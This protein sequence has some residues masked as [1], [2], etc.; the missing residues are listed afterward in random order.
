VDLHLNKINIGAVADRAVRGVGL[1]GLLALTLGPIPLQQANPAT[2]GSLSWGGNSSPAAGGGT[3]SAIAAAD[4]SN[5]D[6]FAAAGSKV[7]RSTNGGLEWSSGTTISKVV[8]A[9]V[10]AVPDTS[11]A[12]MDSNAVAAIPGVDAD[13]MVMDLRISPNY[14]QDGSI[15]ALCNT[16]YTRTGEDD[17]NTNSYV[18]VSTNNGNSWTTSTYLND[19]ATMDAI[20]ASA[21]DIAPNFD[22]NDGGDIA[23]GLASGAT[24]TMFAR[25]TGRGFADATPDDAEMGSNFGP[26]TGGTM[27]SVLA[28]SFSPR[29]TSLSIVVRVVRGATAVMEDRATIN[30]GNAGNVPNGAF[31]AGAMVVPAAGDADDGD[32]ASIVWPSDIESTANNYWVGV[33]VADGGG[34]YRSS[35]TFQNLNAPSDTITGLVATGTFD[36]ANMYA[37]DT[38][39]RTYRSTNGGDRW[40]DAEDIDGDQDLG[41]LTGA[42]LLAMDGGGTLYA[43]SADA[44]SGV[45]RSTNGGSSWS[46][47]GLTNTAY[48]QVMDLHAVNGATLFGVFSDGSASSVFRTDNEGSSGDWL[49]VNRSEGVSA[50]ECSPN[51]SADGGCYLLRGGQSEQQVLRS[52]NGGNNFALT[53]SDPSDDGY[54]HTMKVVSSS[55]VFVG[56]SE[57]HVIRTSDGGFTWDM[58]STDMG[59]NVMDIAISPEFATDNTLLVSVRST[60]D[61]YEVWMSSDGGATF[62]QVGSSS[63]PWDSGSTNGRD[64]WGDVEFSPL[65]PTD[66]TVYF[67]PDK[68]AS[69]D[70]I[71]RKDLSSTSNWGEVGGSL[72][73]SPGE[74][75]SQLFLFEAAGSPDGYAI[76]GSRSGAAEF[77]RHYSPLSGRNS[78]D[79][80]ASDNDGAG[81]FDSNGGNAYYNGQ[82]WMINGNKIRSWS[83]SNPFNSGVTLTSPLPG[84]SVPTNTGDNGQPVAFNWQ[85][86][87]DD[88]QRY[89]IQVALDPKFVSLI[90]NTIVSV[91][92]LSLGTNQLGDGATYYWR[93]RV[94]GTDQTAGDGDA[95]TTTGTGLPSSKVA[96]PGPWS[97]SQNFSV[98]STG[99]PTAPTASL[100][101]NNAQLP[102]L[103]TNLS[104]NNPSGT[105]QVQ[106]Q[107]TPLNGD[108]PGIDLIYGSSISNYS[109][110]APSFGVGPYVMLPGATYTWRVR[111]TRAT[112]SIGS[113]DSS[114][115][116]FSDPRTF[117]TAAPNAGTIQGLA[118]INGEAT[119]DTTP[120]LQWKDANAAMFY[121]EVQLSSDPNFG[122]AGAVAPVYWNLI[123]A[124]VSTPPSSWT[125]PDSAALTAGT[126]YWRTRQRVQ[127]T[128]L[129]GAET[130]IAWTP[131]QM[132]SVQ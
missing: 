41:D 128:P 37:T 68:G 44:D 88:T 3:V 112:T 103:S 126:Y 116:P 114:W 117:T 80:L 60:A 67:A 86:V 31:V 129:G 85:Q 63:G 93:V 13:C 51:V 42:T 72:A 119:S 56:S 27:G 40:R 71:F 115:G 105:T 127:A 29:Y 4:A 70:D 43:A 9:G 89:T 101:L 15:V 78:A 2:A 132:F 58:S 59:N 1:V 109:V 46:D 39:G 18:A 102:G 76:Y 77:D 110:P 94:E 125:V 33:N 106:V 84:G 50:I 83:N 5:G 108:G 96:N 123:H 14:D 73:S 6:V 75:Y 62:T 87:R 21:F 49:R 130:G 36:D 74:P 16:S 121:Y 30:R 95:A 66:M 32:S 113:D 22:G 34:I 104:W 55:T 24:P 97:A 91:P 57:G 25:W 53:D 52:T 98:G 118:P 38:N 81:A 26:S 17:A 100:P 19:D 47:T 107:V 79:W 7:F 99:A 28:I 122:E 48:S 111:T 45:H 10:A 82:F 92:F 23:V 131:A 69:D 12:D 90:E 8:S 11:D 54:I 64:A 35:G 124:G 20:Q 120:T 61:N 65:Y